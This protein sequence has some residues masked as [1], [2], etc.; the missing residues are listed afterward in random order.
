MVFLLKPLAVVLNSVNVF[1]ISGTL[2]RSLGIVE[3]PDVVLNMLDVLTLERYFAKASDSFRK[4]GTLRTYIH[5][6]CDYL[7]VPRLKI[8]VNL[9]KEHKKEN[10]KDIL[11]Y[12]SVS[13]DE[14]PYV[15]F[16]SQGMKK[17][18][19]K[20]EIVHYMQYLQDGQEDFNDP[21]LDLGYEQEAE[22]LEVLS[23]Y[24]LKTRLMY[25]RIVKILT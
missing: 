19:V 11:A 12:F 17:S 13:S 16:Y 5:N 4:K 7:K 8:I 23:E 2:R 10:G 18:C 25:R 20:H 1:R 22:A 14:Q 21:S 3:F 6:L 15:V 9:S 24:E